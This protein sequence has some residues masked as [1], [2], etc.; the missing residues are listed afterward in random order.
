MRQIRSCVAL[1][2]FALACSE[3]PPRGLLLITVDTLRADALGA[4]GA[5]NGMTPRL[6]ALA[7]ESLVFDAAY[8]AAPFTYPSLASL[9]S[10]RYPGSLGM[11]TNNSEIPPDV[12]TL[13]STLRD[14]GFATGAVIGSHVLYK[15]KLA[16]HFQVYDRKLSWHPT[17][18]NMHERIAAPNTDAALALL[19]TLV[20]AP[21]RARA[22]WMLWVHYQDP[23]GPYIPPEPFEQRARAREPEAGRLE[24]IGSNHGGPGI[25]EYQRIG[26]ERDVAFYRARYRAEVAYMDAELG[27]LL[28]GLAERALRESTMLVFT[29]DHGEALGEH[30]VYFAHGHDLTDELTHVPLLIAG[31]GIAPGRRRDV[32]SLVDLYP[33]LLRR[34]VGAE[35]ADLPG[36]DLLAPGATTRE[37]VAH[38]D[39]LAY[40]AMRHTGLVADGYK[41]ILDWRDGVWDARLFRRG[42]EDV[43]LG[44]SAPQ[45]AARLRERLL[46]LQ[47][48]IEAGRPAE[49]RQE[50]TQAEREQLEALGYVDERAP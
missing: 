35:P 4:Y 50:L 49:V 12:P 42:H 16:K 8:A 40:S 25:P 33:T 13:A 6:D 5:A 10:G 38:F 1:L 36:R 30:D 31:P 21:E 43:N 23:H 27:R 44:P 20:P 2:V 29:A 15:K 28:D 32:V 17:L 14:H 45:I 22:R 26:D 9:L 37:S 3:T 24:P 34:L 18:P 48:E 11:R 46:A 41:L 19:D 39:T 47:H 7:N